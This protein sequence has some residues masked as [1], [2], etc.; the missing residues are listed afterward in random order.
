VPAGYEVKKDSSYK[1]EMPAFAGMTAALAVAALALLPAAADAARMCMPCPAGTWSDGSTNG[2]C[3][4]CPA[5]YLCIAGIKKACPV[6]K[7][8]PAG[9]SV[10]P[11]DMEDW[12]VDRVDAAVKKLKGKY[13]SIQWLP[14]Q[15]PLDSDV[16]D[17][18]SAGP[19]GGSLVIKKGGIG[20]CLDIGFGDLTK[21]QCQY[22]YDNRG[23][24]DATDRCQGYPLLRNTTTSHDD[25][26]CD[27]RAGGNWVFIFKSQW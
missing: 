14:A 23:V 15:T 4:E 18:I 25:Y 11:L 2:E 1:H 16:A 9:S 13:G 8:C 21:E 6:G 12:I 20:A 26:P 19:W 10:E 24:L 5:G 27:D 22:L 7:Y 3:R 17:I